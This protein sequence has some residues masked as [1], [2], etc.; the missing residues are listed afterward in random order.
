[1]SYLFFA[2]ALIVTGG[3]GS[4]F[5][6]G[7]A[8]LAALLSLTSI[9]GAT[10]LMTKDAYTVLFLSQT[11]SSALDLGEPLG[12][13]RLEMDG[14][15]SL[16]VCLIGASSM[17][18]GLYLYE[19][20]AA[21]FKSNPAIGRQ[22][23]FFNMLVAFMI[24]A[25]TVKNIIAFV[26][27]WEIMLLC[28][29]FILLF[30]HKNTK[31]RNIALS[32]IAYMHAGAMFLMLGFAADYMYCGSMDFKGLGTLRTDVL[33]GGELVFI[34]L[35]TGFAI[36]SGFTPFHCWT[37]KSPGASA[38]SAFGLLYGLI[39]NMG[40]YGILRL[41]AE[42][43]AP[44]RYTGYVV[45]IVSIIT[46]LWGALNSITQNDMQRVLAYNS[47]GNVGI[48]GIGIGTGLIGQSNNLP[49]MT[50]LGFGGA[51]LHTLNHTLFKGLLLYSAGSIYRGVK[52]NNIN[53]MGGLIKR[54]PLTALMFLCGCI[55]VC[56]LPPLNGFIG[57]AAIFMGLFG[58]S[59]TTVGS[60]LTT[61]VLGMA[62]LTL[63]NGLTVIAF[64]K[65]AGYVLLGQP[66]C[67]EASAAVQTEWT[68]AGMLSMTT[69]VISCLALGLMPELVI[70]SFNNILRCL[71][72]NSTSVI[73]DASALIA[74][75]SKASLL[76]ITLTGALLLI[77]SLLPNV[78]VTAHRSSVRSVR[79][80]TSAFEA[81]IGRL[82]SVTTYLS[83]VERYV[84]KI[85]M[86][87]QQ[88][89]DKCTGLL[90]GQMR[91]N[92]LYLLITLVAVLLLL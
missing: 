67:V 22:Y 15:S 91:H 36:T 41:S 14:L 80:S 58:V 6:K 9:A 74:S 69:L 20:F 34:L 54:M 60:V 64:S 61:G 35:L 43:E 23:L 4:A 72:V 53:L 18:S 84:D 33:N 32:Y 51:M 8:R 37:T 87:I 24:V 56:G 83:T 30:E 26:I 39:I 52:T 62:S 76:P 77:R 71:H 31:T 92:M 55:C 81:G 85:R 7:S 2:L 68:S 25:V 44:P 40:I 65:L 11:L 13:V 50:A 70:S 57:E 45:L 17:L 86:W 49:V 90:D 89:L 27:A 66:R 12:L 29:F 79:P 78:S 38:S 1:M 5:C 63:I 46:G 59:T 19:Y 48:I 47:V 82:T 42:M 75:I 73:N 16:F 21:Y 88:P 28:I 10:A 3:I